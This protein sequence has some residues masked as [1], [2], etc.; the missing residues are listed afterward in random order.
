MNE[1]RMPSSDG[2][3]SLACYATETEQPRV[4]LQISHGMCEY[5]LRYGA[6]A[7]YLSERGPNQ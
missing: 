6:F 5:F 4:L 1:F 3:T 7:E 2:R